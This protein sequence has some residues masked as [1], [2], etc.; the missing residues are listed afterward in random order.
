MARNVKKFYLM[1]LNVYQVWYAGKISAQNLQDS[2]VILV[3]VLPFY[4]YIYIY[5]I[6]VM[7]TT[8]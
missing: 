5:I 3:K 1:K 6:L 4:I 7:C 8:H 2:L